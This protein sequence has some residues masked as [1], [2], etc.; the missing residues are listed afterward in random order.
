MLTISKQQNF[1]MVTEERLENKGVSH[2]EM[3]KIGQNSLAEDPYFYDLLW[4]SITPRARADF[5]PPD[6]LLEWER[7][8][9]AAPEQ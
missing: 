5:V 4:A 6:S 1:K 9:L 8:M 3:A 7:M 2:K